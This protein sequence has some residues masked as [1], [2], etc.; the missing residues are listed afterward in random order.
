MRT[1]NRGS[2]TVVHS[3]LSGGAS[4]PQFRHVAAGLGE[5]S[6]VM[7]VAFSIETH[8]R[9]S[10][11]RSFSTVLGDQRG[12]SDSGHQPTTMRSPW[13]GWGWRGFG[14]SRSPTARQTISTLLTAPLSVPHVPA[15]TRLALLHGMCPLTQSIVRSVRSVGPTTNS[16]SSSSAASNGTICIP[17]RRLTISQPINDG[18]LHPTTPRGQ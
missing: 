2:S 10:W 3:S 4:K 11:S 8:I 6:V 1:P 17:A 7:C 16:G 9:C 15:L 14:C 5:D 12:S 13:S 18:V